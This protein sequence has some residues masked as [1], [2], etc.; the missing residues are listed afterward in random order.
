MEANLEDGE[1]SPKTAAMIASLDD[2]AESRQLVQDLKGASCLLA[3]CCFVHAKA[4]MK[5]CL[6]VTWVLACYDCCDSFL[7]E[8]TP[9]ATAASLSSEAGAGDASRFVGD[10]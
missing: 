5:F 3:L 9:R 6:D 1:F 10:P 7:F 4:Y 2:S 8:A